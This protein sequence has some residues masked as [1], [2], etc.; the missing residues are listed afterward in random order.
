MPPRRPQPTNNLHW[1]SGRDRLFLRP[2]HRQ[3]KPFD[4]RTES[5][6]KKRRAILRLR[7][8]SSITGLKIKFDVI[9][10]AVATNWADSTSRISP[11]V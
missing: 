10:G 6:H 1:F 11:V 7:Y 3:I 2:R 8:T 5:I 9:E 4:H